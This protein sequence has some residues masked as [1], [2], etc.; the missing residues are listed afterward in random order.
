MEMDMRDDP[1]SAQKLV[2]MDKCPYCN[3][4]YRYCFEIELKKMGLTSYLTRVHEKCREFIMF[5][6][7]HGH[8]RGTQTIDI[9][10]KT[11]E[12]DVEFYRKFIEDEENIASFYHLQNISET[13]IEPAEGTYAAKKAEYYA[14]LRS[15]F[16]IAWMKHFIAEQQD[17]AFTYN[18]KE[19]LVVVTLNLYDVI[20]F[21][22]GFELRDFKVNLNIETILDTFQYIKQKSVALG[23]KIMSHHQ[24]P[25]GGM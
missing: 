17:F 24:E 21:T 6:D 2:I 18:E 3:Q 22:A 23:E 5:L 25:S 1:L 11:K 12:K 15:E 14:I 13:N 8:L 9:A 19:D 10:Q 20:L 4:T 16:Y 7:T